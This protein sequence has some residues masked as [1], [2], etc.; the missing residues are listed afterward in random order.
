VAERQNRPHGQTIKASRVPTAAAIYEAVA[1]FEPEAKSYEAAVAEFAA[2]GDEASL[3]E[4]L[5]AL[6]F[7]NDEISW[8]AHRR[9]QRMKIG[10]G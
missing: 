1:I 6:G 7:D 10:Y 8:H 3:W 4:D 9:G 5:R 2:D